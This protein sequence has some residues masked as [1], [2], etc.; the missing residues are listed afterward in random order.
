M[1]KKIENRIYDLLALKLAGST[2]I[3]ELQELESYLSQYPDF[4]FLND[5][6]TKPDYAKD[7]AMEHAQQT[8]AAHYYG[9]IYFNND[10]VD[11]ETRG[12]DYP[13]T[14]PLKSSKRVMKY[15][16]GVA[17]ILTGV[18]FFY[19]LPGK[20]SYPIEKNST[21]VA[22][23]LNEMVTR[24][25]SKSKILL[26]DG[27]SVT[28]NSDSKVSYNKNFNETSREVTLTG[29]AFFEV[30]HDASRPFVVHTKKAD[31]EVL[32][33]TFNVRDYPEDPR[34]ETS[35]IRGKVKVE[36]KGIENKSFVL[37]PSEKLTISNKKIT[38]YHL[39]ELTKIDSVIV[40]TAWI[41]DKVSFMDKPFSEIALELERQF[42]VSIEF[43]NEDVKQYIYTGVYADAKIEDILDILKIIKPFS[44]TIIDKKVIIE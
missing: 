28:L 21:A 40:E 26:P 23:D 4:R 44:Y 11:S 38:D 24:K 25:G 27:T 2:T 41:N 13:V 34:F 37:K 33:T 12:L 29:E 9:K 15:A 36:M 39:T 7:L 10:I 20:P 22:A 30:T 43:K 35:L 17:A 16:I 3:E 14:V 8:Y 5:E 18:I 19:F 32:G 42:N 1:D 31:I 6:L